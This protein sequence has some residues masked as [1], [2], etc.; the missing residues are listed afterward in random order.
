VASGHAL[1]IEL[2]SSGPSGPKETPI[3][4][5]EYH[6]RLPQE[7]PLDYPK[8]KPLRA[9]LAL[10]RT[11]GS[12][13]PPNVRTASHLTNNVLCR[14]AQTFKTNPHRCPPKYLRPEKNLYHSILPSLSKREL[15]STC[16]KHYTLLNVLLKKNGI[17]TLSS[18][19]P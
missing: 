6:I 9:P 8:K 3:W 18:F 19:A 2:T 5:L 1:S 14:K 11:M 17:C 10:E 13:S 15:F 7:T 16:V 12:R 4:P